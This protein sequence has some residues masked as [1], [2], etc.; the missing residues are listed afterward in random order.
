MKRE[1]AT[2]KQEVLDKIDEQILRYWKNR[3][4]KRN[5]KIRIRSLRTARAYIQVLLKKEKK[6]AGE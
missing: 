5:R 3:R 6:E 4:S 2:T 1:K